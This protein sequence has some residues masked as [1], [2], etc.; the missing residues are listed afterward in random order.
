M[1]QLFIMTPNTE[2]LRPL[3]SK[4]ITGSIR[5]ILNS[6]D[7]ETVGPMKLDMAIKAIQNAIDNY[8]RHH[9]DA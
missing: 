7:P 4:E 2:G 9:P 1:I 5:S 3:S 6:V 8:W